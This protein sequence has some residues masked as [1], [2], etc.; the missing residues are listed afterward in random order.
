MYP[1]GGLACCA[2][3]R[4]DDGFEEESGGDGNRDAPPVLDGPSCSTVA[5][6]SV[7][8]QVRFEGVALD[9][10]ARYFVGGVGDRAACGAAGSLCRLF[11]L[12]R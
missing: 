10:L 8:S 5:S 12:D 9:T 6:D 2:A 1:V 4:A 7:E 3:W 11:E